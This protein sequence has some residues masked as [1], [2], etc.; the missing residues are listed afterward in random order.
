[1]TYNEVIDILKELCENE[2]SIN[3]QAF[4][5]LVKEH[6]D[7]RN[8]D[9]EFYSFPGLAYSGFQQNIAG[10]FVRM[11]NEKVSISRATYIYFTSIAHPDR[12]YIYGANEE[13]I[14]TMVYARFEGNDNV[15]ACNYQYSTGT[16]G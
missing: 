2:V 4:Q 14:I 8:Y 12:S 6:L 11:F 1:M 5:G 10:L 7:T 9:K 13:I 3:Y 16:M 15:L